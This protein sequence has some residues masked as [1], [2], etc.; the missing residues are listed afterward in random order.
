MVDEEEEDDIIEIT[1]TFPLGQCSRTSPGNH[2]TIRRWRQRS[3]RLLDRQPRT[4]S[5]ASYSRPMEVLV[6]GMP[7]E[8]GPLSA[9]SS[10]TWNQPT[11]S[12]LATSPFPPPSPGEPQSNRAAF[13]PRLGASST[14]LA[15]PQPKFPF[16][17]SSI[18]ASTP[19]PKPSET[20]RRLEKGLEK[21]RS[22]DAIPV[23]IAVARQRQT[24]MG[25]VSLP[26]QR[27]AENVLNETKAEPARPDTGNFPGSGYPAYTYPMP[28]AYPTPYLLPPDYL[29]LQQQLLMLHQ[30]QKDYL[31]SAPPSKTAEESP[32]PFNLSLSTDDSGFEMSTESNNNLTKE[33]SGAG[34]SDLCDS[35]N[36]ES[37]HKE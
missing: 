1:S 12:P 7:G 2:A 26:P 9:P 34:D 28:W 17:I 25:K 30:A 21:N 32:K 33:A 37:S 29:Y 15:I 20:P 13:S 22:R 4:H 36:G 18:V 23:G 11:F 6:T 5:A 8:T 19:S 14:P 31:P 27:Q 3:S 10:C 16:N 24:D 35:G